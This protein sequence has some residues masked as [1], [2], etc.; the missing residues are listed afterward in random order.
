VVVVCTASR[1]EDAA[2]LGG[3]VS[4][5]ERGIWLD[6]A[7]LRVRAEQITLRVLT[8]DA[9]RLAARLSEAPDGVTVEW[10]GGDELFVRGADLE[11]AAAHVISSARSEAI[12]IDALRYDAPS[13]YALAAARAARVARPAEPE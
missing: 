11:R 10:A 1:L 7:I 6:P 9:E 5:L 4:T 12:S 8:S 3:T 13:L 2:P